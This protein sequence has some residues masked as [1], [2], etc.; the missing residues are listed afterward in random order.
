MTLTADPLQELGWAGGGGWD[1]GWEEWQAFDASANLAIVPVAGWGRIRG[2]ENMVPHG[3]QAQAKGMSGEHLLVEVDGQ[4]LWVEAAAFSFNAPLLERSWTQ[5]APGQA[6]WRLMS[7]NVLADGL[8]QQQFTDR[9]DVL[10]WPSRRQ[11]L[12]EE[13]DRVRPDVLGLSEVNHFSE[14]RA[15]LASR[16]YHGT[17]V[18]KPKSPCLRYGA[19]A[20]GCALFVSG[21]FDT[22]EN[23]SFTF[24]QCNQV[25]VALRLRDRVL[26]LDCV[27]A[28]VH[29]K[30]G[31]TECDEARLAQVKELARRA[32][33]WQKSVRYK[34]PIILAGDFNEPPGSNVSQQLEAHSYKDLYRPLALP[35]TAMDYTWGWEGTIDFV[36]GKH[37][38]AKKAFNL[39]SR[40]DIGA[41]GIPNERYP[42]DHFALALDV[43]FDPEMRMLDNI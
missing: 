21:R 17:W 43:A 19:P 39:P 32:E 2:K 25:C 31:G 12:L 5:L 15:A 30:C 6:D 33:D 28:V 37:I 34:L 35:F 13:V 38:L 24:H 1:G 23:L 36:W 11:L 42:S 9:R 27:V 18:P 16:G 29:F 7:W 10:D 3:T 22:L 40:A 20:D 26:Q 41:Q 4:E 14:W 8:A